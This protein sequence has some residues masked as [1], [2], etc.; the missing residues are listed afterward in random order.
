VPLISDAELKEK[1]TLEFAIVGD[2]T[3]QMGEFSVAMT[4]LGVPSGARSAVF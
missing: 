2:V 3:N 1:H 4:V